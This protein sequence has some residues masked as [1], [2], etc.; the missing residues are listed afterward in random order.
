LRYLLLVVAL[1]TPRAPPLL[2]LNEPETSLHP[3]LLPPLSRL[4]AKAAERSQVIVVS[5]SGVLIDTLRGQPQ[6]ACYE[7]RKELGETVVD[8]EDDVPWNWPK[9]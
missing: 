7:L 5:H 2:V 4:I 8:S 6:T 1:L 9:R 3:S